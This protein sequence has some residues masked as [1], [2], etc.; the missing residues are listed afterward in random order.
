M[1]VSEH[2]AL[3]EDASC[4]KMFLFRTPRTGPHCT[5]EARK[6]EY[7]RPPTPKPRK[8][9]KTPSSL[10]MCKRSREQEGLGS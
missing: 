4:K 7:D 2:V 1:G 3:T 6:L 10:K 8:E 5:V 9:G